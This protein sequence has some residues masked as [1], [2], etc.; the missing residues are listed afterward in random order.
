[1]ELPLQGGTEQQGRELDPLDLVRGGRKMC[2][3]CFSALRS[4]R[5]LIGKLK[6]NIHKVV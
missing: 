6:T 1:M 5:R 2:R 3:R 4:C